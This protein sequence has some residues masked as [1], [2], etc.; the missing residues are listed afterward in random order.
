M[1]NKIQ[2][3]MRIAAMI[4]AEEQSAS[5]IKS[6]RRRFVNAVFINA[7][8]TPQ[9]IENIITALQDDYELVLQEKELQTIL[10]DN[11][12]FEVIIGKTKQET[13]YYL[14]NK[15][16]NK[17][18]EKSAYSIDNAIQEFPLNNLRIDVAQL[19]NLL[20]RYLYSLLN[21]NINAYIQLLEKKG[22]QISPIIDPNSFNETEIEIINNFIRWDNPQ[23]DKALFELVNYCIDYAS[24]INSID[25]QDIVSALKNKKLYLDNTLIYRAIGINGDFRKQRVR[26]LLQ[27]CIDSGQ[28][29]LISSITRKEFFET[30]DYHINHLK[31]TAPYG[32][33]KP[34]LFRQYT[35]GFSIYQ[36]YHEWRRTKNTYAYELF[37]IH[38]KN[39]YETLLKT[40]NITEDF[41]QQFSD[42]KDAG[43]IERYAD[44]IMQFKRQK[45]NDLHVNDAK[46]MVWIETARK[47]CNHNVRDTKFYFVTSDRRLQEWDLSHSR[48]QPITMLPSQWLALLLKYYSRSNNDFKTFVSF[49]TIPD[50]KGQ[51][52]PDELQDILAGISEI[53]EEFQKQDDIVSNLLELN[54]NSKYRNREGAKKFAKDKIES[55]YQEKIN[56]IETDYQIKLNE[57]KKSSDQLSEKR[58][59]QMLEDFQAER[60]KERI[61]RIEERIENCETLLKAKKELQAKI[62]SSCN[63]K[64]NWFR[65]SAIVLLTLY[66]II[67]IAL[68]I[69]YDWNTME[70]I[71]FV[72]GLIIVVITIVISLITNKSFEFWRIPLIYRNWYYKKQ[73]LK[74]NINNS[75]ISDLQETIELL[76]QQK[77]ELETSV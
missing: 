23:K 24:A 37:R 44:E 13:Q 32:N 20:H 19:R 2:T 15:R 67:M 53:T 18:K 50:E 28:Q 73:C 61:E 45:N 11:R 36:Y 31:K 14:S 22:K 56:K 68:I 75:D 39:E 34:D 7:D 8:N 38:L 27:R 62:D 41:K 16:F 6:V 66:V 17:L 57:Q 64:Y 33:I 70:P 40:Y 77:L 12:Y 65:I 69:I 5:T 55:E 43:V 74:F 72:S 4:Y 26:N 47:D 1:A 52:T 63:N 71:T 42:E 46:N 3:I 76:K 54:C 30:I 59:K 49:L 29:L 25:P 58:I 48:N 9:T 60:K 51:V 21:T 35:G 10:E